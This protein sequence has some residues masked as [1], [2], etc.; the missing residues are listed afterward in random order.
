MIARKYYGRNKYKYYMKDAICPNC[1]FKI[2]VPVLTRKE[3]CYTCKR[4]MRLKWVEIDKPKPTEEV[5]C[6]DV[7]RKVKKYHD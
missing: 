6:R 7:G 5:R 1:Q 4:P 3:Y 2:T